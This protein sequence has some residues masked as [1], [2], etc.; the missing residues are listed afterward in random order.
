MLEASTTAASM[1]GMT[2][3]VAPKDLDTVLDAVLELENRRN[4]IFDA[5]M[6]ALHGRNLQVDLTLS[7]MCWDIALICEDTN[8]ITSES[9]ALVELN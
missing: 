3:A 2:S 8:H 4:H 1:A 5:D 7:D 6:T 9:I